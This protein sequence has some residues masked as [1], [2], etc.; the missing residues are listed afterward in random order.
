METTNHF[1]KLPALLEAAELALVNLREEEEEEER[2][3]K[4]AVLMEEELSFKEDH[5]G[6][7]VSPCCSGLT[8]EHS[9]AC[10]A[11]PQNEAWMDCTA[12][13]RD[14]LE[15]RTCV[16]FRQSVD[17]WE[18]ELE[19]SKKAGW[20]KAVAEYKARMNVPAP[21]PRRAVEKACLHKRPLSSCP[22]CSY[23]HMCTK[24]KGKNNKMDMPDGRT[25]MCT[26]RGI[27]ILSKGQKRQSPCDD[28]DD[29]IEIIESKLVA[30][31]CQMC[32]TVSRS[33]LCDDCFIFIKREIDC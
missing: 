3:A 14:E 2:V 13:C 28:S 32:N 26:P 24:S 29:D 11:P 12:S 21:K 10:A 23:R 4:E 18:A 17:K 20:E 1:E 16:A 8:F 5:F 27:E 19:A 15:H 22:G 30:V 33:N 6:E 7:D 25:V 31:K 9:T